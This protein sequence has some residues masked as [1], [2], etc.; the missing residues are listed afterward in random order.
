MGWN[1]SEGRQGL[2]KM[3]IWMFLFPYFLWK[4]R[5]QIWTSYYKYE[6]DFFNVKSQEV[7]ISECNSETELPNF[8]ASGGKLVPP[9]GS[10]ILKQL[11]FKIEG[12]KNASY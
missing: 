7:H 8:Q 10:D 2:N 11:H 5:V 12:E 4:N 6:Q 1:I 3:F 9:L